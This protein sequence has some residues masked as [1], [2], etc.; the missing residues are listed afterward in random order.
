MAREDTLLRPAGEEPIVGF[1]T[2]GMHLFVEPQK[3]KGCSG[4]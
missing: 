4:A 3:R 2:S 1:G